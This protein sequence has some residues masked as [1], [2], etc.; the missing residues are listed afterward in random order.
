MS[1]A[2]EQKGGFVAYLLDAF[3]SS[4]ANRTVD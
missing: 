1:S 2:I 3:R 4:V